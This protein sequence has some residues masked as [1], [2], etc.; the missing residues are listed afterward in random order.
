MFLKYIHETQEIY[1]LYIDE[2]LKLAKCEEQKKSDTAHW[3]GNSDLADV[4]PH[5]RPSL[6][7]TEY[8]KILPSLLVLF[9]NSQPKL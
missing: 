5:W 4:L 2:Y 7:H 6:R 1:F 9:L 3:L 8:L